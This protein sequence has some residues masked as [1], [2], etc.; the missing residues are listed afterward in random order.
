MVMSKQAKVCI[1][2]E[3]CA[4]LP[5]GLQS[6]LLRWGC[7][8]AVLVTKESPLRAQPSALAGGW[9]PCQP[10]GWQGCL[11][12]RPPLPGPAAAARPPAPASSRCTSCQTRPRSTHI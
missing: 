11:E 8:D 10:G 3:G 1:G 9:R 7:F 2:T 12:T 5:L 4:G 6:S